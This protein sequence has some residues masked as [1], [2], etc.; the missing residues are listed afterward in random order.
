MNF[1][2]PYRLGWFRAEGMRGSGGEGKVGVVQIYP[3][4]Q[5][6]LHRENSVAWHGKD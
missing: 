1:G 2:G 5:T 3:R 6:L 4:L